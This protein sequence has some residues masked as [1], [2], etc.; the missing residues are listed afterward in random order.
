MERYPTVW[1]KMKKQ[2]NPKMIN[3]LRRKIDVKS[4]SVLMNLH[5][6]FKMMKQVLIEK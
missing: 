2:S 1:I 3:L 4:D 6:S 5:Q